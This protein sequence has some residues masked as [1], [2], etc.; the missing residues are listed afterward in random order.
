MQD[1]EEGMI[2]KS[3]TLGFVNSYLGMAAAAFYDQKLTGVAML[4]SVVLAIK[5]FIMN[6]IKLRGQRKTMLPKFEAFKNTMTDY[7]SKEEN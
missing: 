2:Q 4:L 3:Y 1:H 7:Q 6:L 5:Q